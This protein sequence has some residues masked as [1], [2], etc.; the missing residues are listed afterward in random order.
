MA[1][2]CCKKSKSC[3]AVS[4]SPITKLIIKPYAYE[5]LLL[6]TD[7]ILDRRVVLMSDNDAIYGLCKKNVKLNGLNAEIISSMTASGN[8][9]ETVLMTRSGSLQLSVFKRVTL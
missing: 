7:G 8:D 1:L 6:A 4:S 2:D 9:F 3:F 5:D